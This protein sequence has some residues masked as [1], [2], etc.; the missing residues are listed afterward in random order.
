M[1]AHSRA[2]NSQ[3]SLTDV[4]AL[5]DNINSMSA[6]SRRSMASVETADPMW[7]GIDRI[8]RSG[9]FNLFWLCQEEIL[10]ALGDAVGIVEESNLASSLPICSSFCYGCAF[11]VCCGYSNP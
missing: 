8:R 10:S 3:T 11:K 2:T 1:L 4:I 5:S 6:L 7:K 9:E